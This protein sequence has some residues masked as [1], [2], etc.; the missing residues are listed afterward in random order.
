MIQLHHEQWKA[1]DV[2]QMKWALKIIAKLIIARLPVPY[3]FWRSLSVF[4][5]GSMDSTDYPVKIFNLH[6][7]RA[8]P[9]GLPSDAVMLELGPG[10]SLASALLGYASG[11]SMTYLVD[12][13]SF[14]RKD[15]A[16]YQTLAADLSNRGL[17][18][19]DLSDALTFN[20]ILQ[21]SNAS[22]LANGLSSLRMIPSESIDFVWS[23]SVLEH[24]R[25]DELPEVLFELHRILKPGGLSSHN[26][27][28]QD[29][30][31]YSLNNLRFSEK[32]WES[33]F[34]AKSGFYTNRVPAIRLHRMLQEAGF[35]IL[36]EE[37]GK[38]DKLPVLRRTL[39]SDFTKF[40]D[41]ELCNRTS[42]VLLKR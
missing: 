18:C 3:S 7:K 34:F 16:F 41:E 24:V 40:T 20:D 8:F 37:F 17:Q 19:P 12:V 15:V 29:H 21:A 6:L 14:A 42:H 31:A 2:L 11:A 25:K 38:W 5:H 13:G 1:R 26:I 33:N 35:K 28:Y 30:L 10:D 36:H 39:H 27:D 9:D 22:Y 23:H 32:L 4:R